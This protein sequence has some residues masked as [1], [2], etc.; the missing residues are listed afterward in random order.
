MGVFRGLVGGF[1]GGGCGFNSFFRAEG[2]G[3]E[4]FCFEIY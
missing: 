2:V 1:L 4:C 3:V